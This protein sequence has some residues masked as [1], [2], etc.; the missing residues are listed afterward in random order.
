MNQRLLKLKDSWFRL[1][2]FAFPLGE[3][4][5]SGNITYQPKVERGSEQKWG[6]RT[7]GTFWNLARK[8]Y[9]FTISSNL[10]LYF[11]NHKI[12]CLEIIFDFEIFLIIA[13]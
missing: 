1:H 11:E 2:N 3:E 4:L 6:W 7:F 8:L 13:Y 12:F 5:H 9:L 10:I